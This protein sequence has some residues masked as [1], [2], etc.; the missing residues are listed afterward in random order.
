M[1]LQAVGRLTYGGRTVRGASCLAAT[2]LTLAMPFGP[3]AT[4]DLAE[5]G[6]QPGTRLGID[7]THFTVNDRPT[8]LFGVSYYGALGAPDETVRRD[9]AGLKKHGFNWVR[10]WAT[11]AAF[12]EDVSAMDRE[13][14]DGQPRRS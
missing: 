14:K 4:R 2:L 9:L 5:G 12:G 10:V 13:G 8:F 3:L 7:R 11:W 6:I 1:P